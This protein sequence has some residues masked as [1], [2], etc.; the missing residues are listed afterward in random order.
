MSTI[1][2]GLSA[3]AGLSGLAMA[4]HAA[5]ESP[6]QGTWTLVAADRI[7]PSGEQVRDYGGNPKGRLMIDAEGRY[8]L[9]IFKSER[10]RF[11]AAD[12]A[13]GSES[14]FKAAVM[15]SSTHYGT[16]A[17]DAH[18]GILTFAIESASSPNW[19]G[20]VQKRKYTLKNGVLS[21]QVPPRPDGGTPL[22]VWRKQD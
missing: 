6:L 16:V 10:P 4:A 19:E 22:S 20:T 12:K 8:S 17:V 1:G 15:G 9:Q 18:E 14:E 2:I 3:L 11:E 13:R 7:L 21:Y 5:S